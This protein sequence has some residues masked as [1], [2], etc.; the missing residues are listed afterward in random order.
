[1]REIKFRAWCKVTKE[2]VYIYLDNQPGQSGV[3]F[4]S[5]SKTQDEDWEEWLQY[6]GLKDKNKKEAYEMDI[7]K[8]ADGKTNE[9]V[10]RDG[11]FTLRFSILSCLSELTEDWEVIGNIYENP[12]LLK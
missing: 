11:G 3:R 1:M 6:T 8:F 12:E 7:I 5:S 2:W 10:W 9:I 4:S